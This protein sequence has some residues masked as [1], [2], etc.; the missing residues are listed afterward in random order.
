MYATKGE[1]NLPSS[2]SFVSPAL[3]FI[4]QDMASYKFVLLNFSPTF[5]TPLVG[6][7]EGDLG[8]SWTPQHRKKEVRKQRIT[9][10]KFDETLPPQRQHNVLNKKSRGSKN[11][12]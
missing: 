11:R 6:Y 8:G 2:K 9:A 4:S 1:Y 5:V 10:R 7:I 12:G 3:G